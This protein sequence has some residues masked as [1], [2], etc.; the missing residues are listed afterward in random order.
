VGLTGFRRATTSVL[1]AA[2]LFAQLPSEL[3]PMLVPASAAALSG[4]SFSTLAV[5][6]G[7]VNVGQTTT[8]TIAVTNDGTTTVTFGNPSTSAPF[9]ATKGTCTGFLVPASN[10]MLT[11]SFAPTSPGIST[12]TL[13]VLYFVGDVG[14]FQD[15]SL[16]GNGVS[17][18]VLYGVNS[19]DDGLSRIDLA[20]G[21]ATLIG[22]LDPDT[23]K[24]TTPIAMAV[25][26][27][28]AVDEVF[29]WN[30]SDG[31]TTGVLLT[32]DRCT[33]LGTKVNP[34]G[35][36]QG[37]LAAL[38]FSPQGTLFGVDS[39]LYTINPT[40]G[41]KTL[42][43]SLG[44]VNPVGG[45]DFDPTLLTT[46]VLY[47]VEL[48]PGGSTT[49]PRLVTINTATG[50]ATVVATLS[51]DVGRIGSIAFTPTGGLLGSAFGGT[52]GN[53]LFDLNKSTGAVSNV[54]T[55]SGGFPPQGMGF[56]AP[57]ADTVPP[58]QPLQPSV[59]G[60]NAATQTWTGFAEPGSLVTLMINCTTTP[61]VIGTAT[62]DPVTGAY[63]ITT[64][65]PSGGTYDDVCVTATDAAGN[66]SLPSAGAIVALDDSAGKPAGGGSVT[67][68]TTKPSV[69][70][71]LAP[72]TGLAPA[73]LS[74]TST[75]PLNFIATF[76][77]N[78]FG[79]ASAD[80]RVTTN[81]ACGT[82]VTTVTPLDPVTLA[83]LPVFEARTK[84]NIQVSG[85][86]ASCI[87]TAAVPAGVAE[88]AARNTNNASTVASGSTNFVTYNFVADT[89]PPVVTISGTPS[90]PSSSNVTFAFSS[91]EAGSTFR[92][93]LDVGTFEACSSPRQ[94]TNLSSGTPTFNVRA[95]DVF[96]NVGTPASFNWTVQ[97]D[98][99]GDGLL[100]SWEMAG[101][102]DVVVGSTTVRVNLPDAFPNR[103]DIY[104]HIDWMQD[105]CHKPTYDAI[106]VAYDA[107]KQAPV[108]NPSGVNG[109]K[110]H[111]DVGP[112]SPRDY[113]LYTIG[114]NYGMNYTGAKWGAASRAG[115]VAHVTTIGTTDS[116]GRYLWQRPAGTT[117]ALTYFEDIK[118]RTGGFAASA[119]EAFYRY[120]VWGHH[121][122]SGG[123]SGLSR[124]EGGSGGGDFM[125]TLG[126]FS[127]FVTCGTVNHGQGTRNDQAGTLMHE[128]GHSLGLG[129][130][131]DEPTNRKPNYLS[132][133]NY[134]FQNTGLTKK[135]ATTFVS[136]V[137]DYSDSLRAALPLLDEKAGLY[138]P[139]GLGT[140]EAAQNYG[141]SWTCVFGAIKQAAPASGPLDWDCDGAI[142]TAPVTTNIN[143][144]ADSKQNSDIACV[145][146][147][148][149]GKLDT[150]P[151][152]LFP[153]QDDYR[154]GP[155]IR[156]SDN[157][158]CNSIPAGDDVLLASE[159]ERPLVGFDDWANIKI[160][161]AR[162]G[163]PGFFPGAPAQTDPEDQDIRAET[164]RNLTAASIDI[165]PADATNT[166]P[167]SGAVVQVAI[168]TTQALDAA[169]V[170]P[171]SVQF[172]PAGARA[173]SSLL[174]DVNGDG[175][176][177]MVLTFAVAQTGLIG[178]MT[179]ACLTGNTG[180]ANPKNFSGC[181]T[182]NT[183]ALNHPPTANAGGPYAG[184]AGT[185][186]TFTGSGADADGDALT[187]SWTFGDGSA[188]SPFS[189]SPTATHTY[190]VNGCFAASLTAR[191]SFGATDTSAAA[192]TVGNVA[193]TV[194]AITA[195]V[196]PV[197]VGTPINVTATFTATCVDTHTAA[198]SWGDGTASPGTV[199]E[200][201]GS[202]SATGSHT[203]T[204]AGVYTLTLTVTD[205][206]GGSAQVQFQFVVVF[207]PA[208]GF[209]TGSG[210]IDSPAGA[211]PVDPELTGRAHFGF[212]SKY[213]KGAT[214]PTGQTH[215]QFKA[216]NFTFRS[217]TYEW[218]VVSGA[219]AQFKGSGS[220]NGVPGY[221]FLLTVTDGQVPGGGGDD[222]FRIRITREGV[223]YDN[224]PAGG[225]GLEN[226]D[227]QI[228]GGGSI[229]IHK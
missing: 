66:V 59:S 202:G 49:A 207:D 86:T 68:D 53:I 19:S 97:Q 57:C 113:D 65:P 203:Y 220:V 130:G 219:K 46:D 195:P 102:F 28:G 157:R 55:V 99:D 134:A 204:A 229:V 223:V 144:N 165:M 190:T 44:I 184:A 27:S 117:D 119:R 201:N 21:Q 137:F 150:V 199:T 127:P 115:S 52:P 194:G 4:S 198:W 196:D 154:S 132:V 89:T 163:Q 174:Q 138:E 41:V 125:V 169:T 43:G 78:V 162:I 208:T 217:S 149:D 77:E 45:A 12:G 151:N 80:A 51:V 69:T 158:T 159:G 37:V 153:G 92:C 35:A 172:G 116:V 139:S 140:S 7:N 73:Q 112:D 216:G 1:A 227:P 186:I 206:H 225:A 36:P 108:T 177:D 175:R 166:I 6:F 176:Q 185:A 84:F 128:L 213:Q 226:A 142:D 222:K 178:G 182:V 129:H 30:N 155:R 193:P 23:T 31:G 29:V 94:Y 188:A 100:D 50:V 62:A 183:S 72:A 152:T 161:A 110:L 126:S 191:D 215:F 136:G 133:M 224:K 214:T 147:G 87:V 56:A 26:Y 101:F 8:Q 211:F 17:T 123:S 104:L 34:A 170:I 71:G 74:P 5:D 109:I 18:W 200:T 107:F 197:A 121:W 32:V 82:L 20:T 131:G 90:N 60:L 209:V 11:V 205:T 25:R 75:Q 76:T 210:W 70:V 24:L 64:T 180:D 61:T 58:P 85:M 79:F 91:N 47:G 146:P 105:T 10:C 135:D 141:T 192:V 221:E 173:T 118:N 22:R 40:T 15:I 16:T 212:V 187:F 171:G 93:Q 63:T 106:K 160:K 164:L 39:E 83:P 143:I 218:L 54:R 95:I 38:A 9:S 168:L 3:L 33:G 148:P 124:S 42:V 103:K 111:V 167:A 145:G 2:L 98:T 88:D 181:G 189:P 122:D 48:T 120:V 81:V 13:G 96:G 14:S 114:M 67:A 179:E 228:I 156:L